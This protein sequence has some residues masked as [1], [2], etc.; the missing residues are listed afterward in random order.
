MRPPGVDHRGRSAVDRLINPWRDPRPFLVGADRTL[1][2]AAIGERIDRYAAEL[3]ARGIR[4]GDR[5]AILSDSHSDLI[6]ALFGHHRSGVVHVPINT[7]YRHEEVGHILTDAAPRL[8]VV[9]EAYAEMVHAVAPT[10]PTCPVRAVGRSTGDEGAVPEAELQDDDPALMIY[11]SGTTAK[12][13]GV[14][15]SYGSLVSGMSA[16][17][18]LWQWSEDHRLV[19]ALP[20]FH[21]HGLCIGVH[22]SV[23][24]RM[25]VCLLSGFDPSAVV[26]AVAAGGTIFMGVPTMYRR[27]V[28]YLDRVPE[29]ATVLRQARL[30][31]SGS[32]PLNP[33]IFARFEAHTG[34]QIVE[35]YGMSETLITLSNRV[36]GERRPGVVGRPVPGVKARVVGDD[37]REVS[38]GEVGELHVRGPSLMTG[39]WNL[40]RGNRADVRRRLVQDRRCRPYR[41]AR[42]F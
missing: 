30:F 1:T 6:V 14:V 35:R 8:V 39:Y 27:L 19:L 3:A 33:A 10:L 29:A 36:Q 34:H 16:L 22:G 31:T 23:L 32:A 28:D 7:R 2:Y 13:K 40:P 41:R 24:H 25:Q 21:V 5:V 26:H 18:N 15:L 38:A 37:G 42:R 11:T 20:L 9:D 17:T 12:S 4:K